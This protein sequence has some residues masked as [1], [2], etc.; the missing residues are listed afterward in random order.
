MSDTR[1][2]LE[3]RLSV[4]MWD[5]RWPRSRVSQSNRGGQQKAAEA[6]PERALEIMRSCVEA[7]G[8]LIGGH[9]QFRTPSGPLEEGYRPRALGWWWLWA[10]FG[11]QGGGAANQCGLGTLSPQPLKT[12]AG[13]EPPTTCD[14]VLLRQGQ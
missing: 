3:R 9:V 11:G 5:E 14:R 13:S 12:R 2:R 10:L 1:A 7:C 6:R 4:E 8:Q